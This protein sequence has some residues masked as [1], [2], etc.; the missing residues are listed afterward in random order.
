MTNAV[1]VIF[2]TIR[3][4]FFPLREVPISCVWN[5]LRNCPGVYEAEIN[6]VHVTFDLPLWP[7]PWS[8]VSVQMI[9]SRDKFCACDLWPPTMTLMQGILYLSFIYCLNELDVCKIVSS[10]NL[11]HGFRRYK[12]TQIQCKWPL[13]FEFDLKQSVQNLHSGC[14][15]MRWP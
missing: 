3:S 14:F 11:D 5:I 1:K 8:R 10:L 4:K 15:S 12:R 13:T 2:H 7:W 9:W 6:S